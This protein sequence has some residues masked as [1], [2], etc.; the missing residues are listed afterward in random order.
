MKY[1]LSSLLFVFFLLLTVSCKNDPKNQEE[2]SLTETAEDSN[3]KARQV[4]KEVSYSKEEIAAAN[5]T[6]KYSAEDR[7]KDSIQFADKLFA[8]DGS[9]DVSQISNLLD[10]EAVKRSAG[11]VVRPE[12][13]L[14]N[15][16]RAITT[17][18]I[19]ELFDLP[20]ESVSMSMGNKGKVKEDT[21]TSCFWRWGNEGVVV[22]ISSNPLPDEVEDWATRYM[23][24]KKSSGE[25]S[26]GDSQESFVFKDFDGPGTY[27]IYNRNT[28]RYYASQ[29]EEIIVALIFNG[30]MDAKKQ[31]RS[32]KVILE[33]IFENM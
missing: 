14:L 4:V 7:M 27:N 3:A 33:K 12:G 2:G 23:N 20:Q 21:S 11:K 32:A 6:G 1:I 22:Q 30:N 17:R 19:A 5:A 28:G 10:N 26:L 13:Q 31:M 16:C 25:Q 18:E 9:Y 24:T 29:G 15:P 8:R